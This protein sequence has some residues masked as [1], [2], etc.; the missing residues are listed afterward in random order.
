MNTA[1]TVGDKLHAI[2]ATNNFGLIAPHLIVTVGAVILMLVSLL[3][4][5]AFRNN[6]VLTVAILGAALWSA[7]SGKAGE[8]V[9]AFNNMVLA[10]L[11][12]QIGILLFLLTGIFI[13]LISHEYLKKRQSD[14]PEYY[15]LLLFAISGMMFMA[16]AADLIT[17]Y[18]GIEIL[19]VALYVM[20][21]IDTKDV[22]STEAGI[23]YFL[24][25]VFA[26]A[27]FLF[28]IAFIYGSV[29]TTSFDAI[30][31]F[32]L[33]QG[34]NSSNFL[35]A[36]VLL[37]LAGMAFK[38]S[39]APFHLWTPDVYEGAPL[40]VTAF[41]STAPKIAT[42]A[43]L[44]RFFYLFQNVHPFPEFLQD[45]LVALAVITMV[46]GN[47]LALNQESVKRM[48]AFSSVTHMGYVMT[49]FATH[50][51]EAVSGAMFYFTA[52]IFMN[53]GTF[54]ILAA[55]SRDKDTN[56]TVENFKGLAA[57]K[58][59]AAFL[60]L[61]FLF[62][63]AGIP[64]MV[65]FAAKF[66]VF[67]AVIHSGM[68]GL[69]IIGILNSAVSAYYYLRI[70]VNMYLKT[71]NETAAGTSAGIDFADIKL[72]LPEITVVSASIFAVIVLGIQPSF[73]IQWLSKI[74]I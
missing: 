74:V 37:I 49:A 58:P 5:N 47:L 17:V 40:S 22:R 63:L 56:L 28:G 18:I 35:Y 20:A 62:S 1:N 26:S 32:A 57:K 24:M 11:F 21:A 69:A 46:V 23:K 68:Y 61:V 36:G 16:S 14:V 52:Y 44:F 15:S 4:R 66:F 72:A 55:M 39:L 10:D 7:C 41:L 45:I 6:A 34:F 71:P 59:G 53:L 67:S 42:F 29:G 30:K 51:L 38:I 54:A 64:P 25:S 13:V 19:S 65:G 9:M 50:S 60:L 43:F 70:I 27:F 12:S 8:I 2:V 73:L 31:E 3:N 33:A 48:L